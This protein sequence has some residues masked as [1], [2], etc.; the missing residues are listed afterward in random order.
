MG[1][2]G[3]AIRGLVR[4]ELGERVDGD[5]AVT[6]ADMIK[7]VGPTGAG[8]S[9]PSGPRG[10][11][12]ARR[13]SETSSLDRRETVER[14]TAVRE[15]DALVDGVSGLPP[16]NDADLDADDRPLSVLLI[17]VEEVG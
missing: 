5:W 14:E 9:F 4:F 16:E 2:L 6:V 12:T 7:R 3:R 10:G 15:L 17:D 1:T 8:G 11:A 13:P